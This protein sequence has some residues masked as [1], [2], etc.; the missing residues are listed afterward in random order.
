MET[1]LLVVGTGLFV[2]IFV[3]LLL[4]MRPSPASARLDEVVRQARAG[5]EGG[6]LAAGGSAAFLE[7]LA[8]PFGRFRSLLGGKPSP[9]LVRRLMLAGYRKPVHVDVFLI[10]R[11]ALPALAGLAVAI[12]VTQNIFFYFIVAIVVGLFAPD[13]WLSHAINKRRERIRLSLPD[14]LDLLSICMEA[15]L[16]M[17]QALVRVGHELE[18]SHR[19][20]SQEFLQINFEQR[21]GAR[22]IDAWKAFADRAA[23]ES[24]RSFV[25]MLVQTDRFGTPISK[26][27]G[28]FSDALRTQRRQRAEELAAK[29]TIKLVIPLVFFIFPDIFVVTVA[30]A[31]I[32]IM[33]NIAHVVG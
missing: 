27:L 24:V 3:F 18:I 2:G 5:L 22:R 21:A 4:T 19:E 14:A 13:F 25:A 20:L 12:L 23:V 6:S 11:L 30:P 29:T 16:G 31:I 15:G 17:D 28:T 7:R 9:V 1:T 33:R 26:A 10:T 32:A 8:K